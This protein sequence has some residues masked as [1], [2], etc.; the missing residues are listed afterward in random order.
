MLY[1]LVKPLATIALWLFYRR[2][3]ISNAQHIPRNKPVVLAANHPTGFVE[4]CILACYLPEPL[5]FLARGDLF[6]QPFYIRLMRSLNLLPLY[7]AKDR[8]LA[9]VKTNY[10][11]FDYCFQALA[12]NKMVLIL[13]EGSAEHEKRL[14]PLK[15]GTGRLAFGTLERYNNLEDVYIIPVGVNYT[16]A[17]QPRSDVMIDFGKPILARDYFSKYQ[18][19]PNQAIADLTEDLREQ[20]A[21]RIVVIDKKEDEA[22]AEYLLQLDRTERPRRFPKDSKQPLL[23]EKAITDKVNC[24][25]TAIKQQLIHLA[26]PYFTRLQQLKISDAA[27][28][29]KTAVIP[30]A[31]LLLLGLPLF[32][33]GYLLN[34]APVLLAKNIADTRVKRIEFYSS[35]WT[36]V[37]IGA[38]LLYWL[39]GLIFLL[40]FAPKG[41]LLALVVVPLLGVFSIYYMDYYKKSRIMIRVSRLTKSEKEELL[42][43]RQAILDYLHSQQ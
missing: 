9:F 39:L 12:E 8:G 17:D 26:K 31:L 6:K 1:S 41:W 42:Q 30:A 16:Y 23:Y 13:A 34:A 3:Y 35:V 38:Y 2:I 43:K 29:Q 32:I 27:L 10:E 22:L 5:H 14:R 18:Q 20:M 28:L 40:I 25:Q 7:R 24:L 33:L 21:E 4:P 15:K 36:A 19:N 37:N 11:T